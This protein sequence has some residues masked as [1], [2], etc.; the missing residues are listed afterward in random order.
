M[1]LTLTLAL[2]RDVFAAEFTLGVLTVDGKSFGYTCEDQD[3]GTHPKVPGATAIPP[4]RYRVR[5]TWSNRYQ[6]MM[7][8]VCDV[9]D[10]RG[11]RIHA[12]NTKVDTKGC[13]LPGLRRTA[14]GVADSKKACAWL[15]AEI[16][17]V[18]AAGGEVW[19]DVQRA[20]GSQLAPAYR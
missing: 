1:I 6:R 14:S 5:T 11:I 4:G 15:E 7:P 13:V 20:P 2:T 17:R 10:F 12:G 18:E 9:P 8:L 19:I 16:A 3:R